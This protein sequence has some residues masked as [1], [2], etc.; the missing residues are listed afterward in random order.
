MRALAA[1]TLSIS[2]LGSAFAQKSQTGVVSLSGATQS[3]NPQQI[4]IIILTASGGPGLSC[5]MAEVWPTAHPSRQA[6]V[7]HSPQPPAG[8]THV[9]SSDILQVGD[10]RHLQN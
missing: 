1:A 3:Q 8:R 2:F 4:R 7:L 6:A 5:C 10:T 9:L